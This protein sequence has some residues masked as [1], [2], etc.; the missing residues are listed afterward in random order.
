M[1]GIYCRISKEK[2]E[3][4]DRSINDQKELGIQKAKELGLE[5]KFFI[6]EGYSGTL[7]NINDRPEFSKLIDDI[8]DGLITSVYAY[9]QSRIERNPQVRF[10]I[11][12][13]LRENGIKLYTYNGFVDLE[14]D[15]SEMLGDI[16]SIMNQ[17]YVK[18][19]TRKVKSVLHR[20]A[21]EGKAHSSIYPYGYAKDENGYLVIDEEEAKIVKRVYSDSLN[22]IGMNKIAENLSA[23]GVLTRYNKIGKGVIKTKNKYT[24]E[25][26]TTKKTD[27]TWSGNSVRGIIKNTIYKGVRNFGGKQY[28]SPIIIEPDYWQTVNENLK[29]NRNNS[30]K[31]VSHKYLLKGVLECGVCGRNMYGR[32]RT[33]K[34]D[35][36]YLCS[37]KRYKKLNCG[38][39]SINIDVIEQYVWHIVL[40]DKDIRKE[41]AEKSNEEKEMKIIMLKDKIESLK[42]ELLRIDGKIKNAIKL[43]LDFEGD[44]RLIQEAQNLRVEE[45][46]VKLNLKNAIDELDFER[47]SDTL[48]KEFIKD[49]RNSESYNAP[50]NKRLELIKKYITRIGIHY[51]PEVQFFFLAINFKF[52]GFKQIFKLQGDEKFI[53]DTRKGIETIKPEAARMDRVD[54]IA[55]ELELKYLG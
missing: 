19:T 41:R 43:A 32:T 16:V 11:K 21:K 38:N 42:G 6:D 36:Y 22:G 30:G 2:E 13:I 5:Y 25:I 1:L 7:E 20:N 39:R 49:I 15:Q 23:E 50:F 34:K 14:D 26:T 31:K 37:S 27:I 52:S 9:D 28:D 8:Q 44:K 47:K 4:K 55:S 54:E 18:L 35:N 53:K 46:D 48:V 45:L 40:R 51:N 29:K 24:G 17:Y 12:K 3:G 10:V 33:N